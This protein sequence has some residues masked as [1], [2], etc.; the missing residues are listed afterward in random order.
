MSRMLSPAGQ[1]QKQTQD[2]Q[3]EDAESN[4]QGIWDYRFMV[5]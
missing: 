4:F 1:S 2:G 5:L 3:F